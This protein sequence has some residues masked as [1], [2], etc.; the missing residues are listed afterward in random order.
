[1]SRRFRLAVVAA[2]SAGLGVLFVLAALRLPGFG[3]K[4]HPYG[5][6]A[7]LS[8]VAET[9][10]TTIS[11][12]NFDQRAFDTVGEELILF[13]SALG[14]VVLLRVVRQA[15]LAPGLLLVL[16]AAVLGLVGGLPHGV[17]HAAALF[18]DHRGYASAVLDGGPWLAAS[19]PLEPWTAAGVLSGVA[20]VVLAAVIAVLSLRHGTPRV[21]RP[22]TS[23]LRAAHSGHVGDYAA[24]LTA[25]VAFFGLLLFTV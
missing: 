10:A 3:G 20:G 2:G 24:W 22:V 15:M 8:A 18:V 13:A 6:R 4:F 19:A 1:V 17:S 21:L 5:E 25:G 23:R 14:A 7:V 9:T 12:V 16:G 11:S